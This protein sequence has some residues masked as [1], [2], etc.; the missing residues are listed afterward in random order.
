MQWI[1]CHDILAGVPH[2]IVNACYSGIVP[3]FFPHVIRK[4]NSLLAVR[5]KTSTAVINISLNTHTHLSCTT[6]CIERV[7][8]IVSW[9]LDIKYI[10]DIAAFLP[11]QKSMMAPPKRRLFSV[12]GLNVKDAATQTVRDPERQATHF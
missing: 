2:G 11:P 6:D 7:F 8:G 3:Q 4:N 10:L 5:S 12:L 9:P 1:V